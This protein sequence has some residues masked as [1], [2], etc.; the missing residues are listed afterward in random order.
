[1][2][3]CKHRWSKWSDPK[4][5][6]STGMDSYGMYVTTRWWMQWRDCT[7]CGKAEMRDVERRT[8]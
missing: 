3:E 5:Q 8:E 4:E 2:T 1:M 7:K 6:Q